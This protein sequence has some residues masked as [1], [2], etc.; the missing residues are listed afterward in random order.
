MIGGIN[1]WM[2]MW[3]N[4]RLTIRAI[5]TVNPRYGVFY[6]AWLYV[7]QTF[8]FVANYWSLG[9]SFSFLS[10]LTAA[11]VLSPFVGYLWLYFTGWVFY[12]TGRWLGGQAPMSHL[13]AAAA[14]S[15][16]PVSIALVMWLILMVVN[17]EWTFIQGISLPSTV[18]I[19]L[20]AFIL[21][22]WSFV[23]L[24]Q[25]IRE[26]QGFTILRS[27]LNLIIASLISSVASILVFAALK[28]IYTTVYYF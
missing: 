6:L 20:I 17:P 4:P 13:R 12:F 15:K 21:G 9:F 28:Y 23:L 16:I 5:V 11:L 27:L 8:F 25:S 10:L 19:Q 22:I 3:T 7:L 14:W 26:I 1:P 24:I 2:C 18:F